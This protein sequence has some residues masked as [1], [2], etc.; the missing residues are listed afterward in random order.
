MG[1]CRSSPRPT[2]LFDGDGGICRTWVRQWQALTRGAVIVRLYQQVAPELPGINHTDVARA[3][4]LIEP[5]GRS[6]G[7]D[8]GITVTVHSIDQARA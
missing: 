2:L 8:Y 3:I 6:S 7:L 1:R 4:C 5:D